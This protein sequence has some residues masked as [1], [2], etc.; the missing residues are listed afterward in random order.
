MK[1]QRRIRFA[2]PDFLGAEDAAARQSSNAGGAE[3]QRQ[4]AVRAVGHDAEGNAVSR[5]MAENGSDAGQGLQ[6]LLKSDGFKGFLASQAGRRI[7][8]AESGKC[9]EDRFA[10][11]A[12]AEPHDVVFG[13]AEAGFGE[14]RRQRA[15]GNGFAVDED[16]V[17]VENEAGKAVLD[18]HGSENAVVFNHVRLPSVEP[19][20]DAAV[21]TV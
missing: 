21:T 1:K 17:T 11:F 16:A 7:L 4:P 9:F 2:R 6:I 18:D 3:R 10:A 19:A 15:G 5:K 12:G 8:H 13:D 14:R 20:H